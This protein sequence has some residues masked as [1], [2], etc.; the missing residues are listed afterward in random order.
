[1]I[2]KAKELVELEDRGCHREQF[3]FF[4][5]I[6]VEISNKFVSVVLDNCEVEVVCL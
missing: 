2:E 4:T 6:G 3:F 1:M 5:V